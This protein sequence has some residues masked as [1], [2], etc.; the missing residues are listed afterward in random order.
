MM[1]SRI[2]NQAPCSKIPVLHRSTTISFSSV[3][4]I[5]RALGYSAIRGALAGQTK[6]IVGSHTV[7]TG[8]VRKPFGAKC[9]R[10]SRGGRRRPHQSAPSTK[11]PAL[12][13]GAPPQKMWNRT[14]K[15]NDAIR[16]MFLVLTS[17]PLV[18][19]RVGHV[20]FCFQ[21]IAGKGPIVI[22]S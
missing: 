22:D 14:N 4:M 10:S 17:L 20:Y 2:F 5:P 11:S 21:E 16:I 6:G 8:S 18:L 1:H 9:H 13:R 19:I 7:P 12:S 3:G 15:M